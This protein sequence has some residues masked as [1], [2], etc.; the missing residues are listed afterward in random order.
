[1]IN[2]KSCEIA[3]LAMV[4]AQR[5]YSIGACLW[6]FRSVYAISRQPRR[7]SKS[8]FDKVW[9]QENQELNFIWTYHIWICASNEAFITV[10]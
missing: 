6:G 7:S 1:M 5:D 3:D 10:G 8:A 2:C 4:A 9:G